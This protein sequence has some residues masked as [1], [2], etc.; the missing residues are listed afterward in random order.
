MFSSRSFLSR[1]PFGDEAGQTVHFVFG[2]VNG[3]GL[4]P[5]IDG[6]RFK[7]LPKGDPGLPAELPEEHGETKVRLRNRIENDARGR[8][9]FDEVRLILV[10]VSIGSVDG[11]TP[12]ATGLDV[13]LM[14][15]VG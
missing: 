8:V 14:E 9:D 4:D 15:P 3:D 6:R 11:E 10:V 1:S 5:V 2:A 12:C 7:E 13:E